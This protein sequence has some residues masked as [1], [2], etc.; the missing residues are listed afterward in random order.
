MEDRLAVGRRIRQ[1]RE[2]LGLTQQ[3]LGEQ[4]GCSHAA[5][6]DIER[7]VTK[8]GVSDLGRLAAVLGKEMSYFLPTRSFQLRH[9]PGAGANKKRL[10][11][12]F[13]RYVRSIDRT[14]DDQP[15]K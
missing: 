10:K 13:L 7:G 9:D 11:E 12:D 2:D 6:S 4:Y 15:E 5:I 1:A 3:Q 14:K 8:L